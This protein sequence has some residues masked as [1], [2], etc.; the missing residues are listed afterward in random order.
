MRLGKYCG[1]SSRAGS[2]EGTEGLDP[3]R[4]RVS[5]CLRHGVSHVVDGLRPVLGR[6][7]LISGKPCFY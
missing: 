7:Q 5:T 2:L 6:L 3:D 1:G 4:E